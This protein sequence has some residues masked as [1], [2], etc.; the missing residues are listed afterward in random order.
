MEAF[1][2]YNCDDDGGVRGV[3]RVVGVGFAPG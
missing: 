3:S 2:V 1:G